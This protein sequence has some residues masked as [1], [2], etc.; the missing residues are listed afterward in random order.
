[1]VRILLIC[2]FSAV[3]SVVNG[4]QSVWIGG[5]VTDSENGEALIGASITTG[6]K[7][8]T[9][10]SPSGKYSL[11]INAGKVQLTFR[12]IGY[13]SEIRVLEAGSGDSINLDI[14]MNRSPA[15]LDEIVVSAGKYEQKLSEVMVSMDII[16][17]NRISNTATISLETLI[18]QTPG[19]EI[20]EE[21]PSIRGGSG[22]S[23]G[24]GSRV[25]V[26]ID[27]LPLLSGDAGDVKWDYL[28]LE[29][30]SQIEIIKGASSVLYGSSALNGIINIRS[31]YPLKE[32]DTKINLY[33]G[34]YLDPSRKE[35][36]W[37][38]RQPLFYGADF[39]HSR[40]IRNLDMVLGASVLEDEEYREN[41]YLKRARFNM[42]LRY[43]NP[44]ISGLQ[45]GL[46][47]NSM[48]VDKSDYL[49]WKDSRSGALRQNPEAVSELQGNR[50]NID[51]FIIYQAKNG[52]RH[53]LKTRH[54]HISNNFKEAVDKNSRSDLLFG[55][56]QYHQNF[57]DKY[58]LSMGLSSTYTKTFSELYGDHSSFNQAAYMQFDASLFSN[59]NFSTGIRFERY[60]LDREVE[61]SNPVFRMGLNYQIA[62]YSFLR[63]SFGQGYRFP[64]VAEKFT[65]TNVGSLNIFPNPDLS[66]ESGW[67]SEIGF[68]QGLKLSEWYGYLD[69]AVFWTEYR[70]MIEFIFDVHDSITF[71]SIDDY[72]FKALNVGD[73]R[74]VGF[75]ISL[76]GE[77][78]IG[79]IP[80][81]LMTGYTFIHPVDLNVASASDPDG[82]DFLKYRHRHSVKADAELQFKKLSSGITAIM[83]SRMERIDEVFLDPLFG[84]LI[85]HGFPDY[86][87][88]HNKGYF[89]LDARCNYQFTPV[90]K[91]GLVIKNILNREYMG[92]PGDIQAPRNIT[93]RLS[94]DF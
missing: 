4:Q 59:L 67:S 7:T 27:D 43:R 44:N 77:G 85:L 23:Y 6:E 1:M 56:Y 79:P 14:M 63:A 3:L 88:E 50:Y 25:L 21:Q 66:S 52:A 13:A 20:L 10:T 61:Y 94:F 82:M 38:D 76:T 2:I 53:S 78:S 28:P 92:R 74:I 87:D 24:A 11:D 16:K 5:F 35:M 91:A 45:Y 80:L 83:N 57:L 60:E 54:F 64:S 58:D 30:I 32:P 48:F 93:L 65:A 51:P 22:Y 71:P 86:W 89:V 19:V 90:I 47:V 62:E 9:I 15:L 72:G 84:N 70:D 34:T 46:S 41:V 36:I 73:T 12:Y 17:P 33:S 37:W 69:L 18:R 42:N 39:T 81:M 49:V 55:E 29:N 75:E 26:L 40:K 31:A 8:G 68:K